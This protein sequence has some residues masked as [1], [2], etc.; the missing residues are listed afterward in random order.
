MMMMT[1]LN[2]TALLLL[3]FTFLFSL[4]S[5]DD[6]AEAERVQSG[7]RVHHDAEASVEEGGGREQE[8]AQEGDHHS[9]MKMMI[10]KLKMKM[11]LYLYCQVEKEMAALRAQQNREW[12]ERR[13]DARKEEVLDPRSLVLGP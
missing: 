3:S 9:D 2:P 10:L 11:E 12:R 5:H 8:G 7:R 4:Q 1:I 6:E 13:E